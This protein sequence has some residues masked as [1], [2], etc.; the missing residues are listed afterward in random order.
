M[1]LFVDFQAIPISDDVDYK[2]ILM[3]SVNDFKLQQL[4][5]MAI[6]LS[7]ECQP[8]RCGPLMNGLIQKNHRINPVN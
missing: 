4:K 2:A 6:A 5:D 8:S 1:P 7:M 3:N